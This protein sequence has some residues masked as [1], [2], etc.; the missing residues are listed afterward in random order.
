MLPATRASDFYARQ[1]C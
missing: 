1:L